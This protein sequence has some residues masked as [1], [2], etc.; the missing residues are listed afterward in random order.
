MAVLV[1][2]AAASPWY[3]GVLQPPFAV[4][5]AM[6]RLA[7]LGAL[8]LA[9]VTLLV[10][11]VR[12]RPGRRAPVTAAGIVT[13]VLAVALI[14]TVLPGS[15]V[16]APVGRR[17][18]AT[19]ITVLSWNTNQ[20][21]VSGSR[22]DRLVAAVHP[23]VVVLPEYFGAITGGLAVADSSRYR[24][25]S[26]DSS[27]STI[28]ISTALG[29]YRL[30]TRGVPPWAGFVVRPVRP[31]SP[32]LAVAH[33]QRTSLTDGTTWRHH[34]AWITSTCAGSN[35]IAVGDFNAAPENLPASRLGTCADVAA[36]LHESSIG[37]WPT[38]LPAGLGTQID[39]AYAGAAWTPIRFAVIGT[40]DD[41]GS[42]H[43]PIVVTVRRD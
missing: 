1:G 16:T 26:W 14:A 21:R 40:E 2:L 37:T 31:G 41:A 27:A 11:L 13:V 35:V 28:F 34:L 15:A 22:I 20:D 33:L 9:V 7:L 18:S 4:F 3:S 8:V 19:S 23:D 43:R 38:V 17:E 25:Y 29:P 12:R 30:D 42:D 24:R 36:T 6:R 39:H 32:T 5:V 10:A